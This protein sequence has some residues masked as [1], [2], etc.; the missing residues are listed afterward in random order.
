MANTGKAYRTAIRINK[1]TDDVVTETQDIAIGSYPPYVPKTPDE[2]KV[3]PEA[4]YQALCLQTQQ[5]ARQ[6]TGVQ[7]LTVTG[8][9]VYATDACA[10]V[11]NVEYTFSFDGLVCQLLEES[12]PT[13][14]S[15]PTEGV[16]YTGEAFRTQIRVTRTING[17]ANIDWSEIVKIGYYFEGKFRETEPGH[18]SSL[19]VALFEQYVEDTK[20]YLKQRYGCTTFAWSNA[21]SHYRDAVSCPVY[22]KTI[23]I[24]VSITNGKIWC[25]PNESI[26]FPQNVAVTVSC[27]KTGG[28]TSSLNILIEQGSHGSL[29]TTIPGDTESVSAVKLSIN[30]P[31]DGVYEGT[32]VEDEQY[33][34][35]IG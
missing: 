10:V 7:D 28:S 9:N 20:T 32:R 11:Q 19:S 26:T 31:V 14:L 12:T 17:I 8:Q 29:G 35:I 33:I 34:Y 18:L 3:L 16:K 22:K 6:L 23:T 2:L 4:D 24:T 25:L 21:P 5:Y 13:L 1:Y 15:S 27:R 30:N